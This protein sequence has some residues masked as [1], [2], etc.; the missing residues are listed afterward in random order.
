[1]CWLATFGLVYPSE[2]TG[3]TNEETPNLIAAAVLLGFPAAGFAQV[4]PGDG[5]QDPCDACVIVSFLG[6]PVGPF[7]I[8]GGGG[9][10]M[11]CE[12]IQSPIGCSGQTCDYALD[13][14]EPVLDRLVQNGA[15]LWEV[16]VLLQHLQC[17]IVIQ[18][19]H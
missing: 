16:V 11:G 14:I 10:L 5:G 15:G 4:Q 13:N 1:M 17:M 18:V 12:P 6:I 9:V 3:G 8:P 2:D 7:C 19:K